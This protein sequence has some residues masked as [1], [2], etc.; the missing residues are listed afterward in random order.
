MT[1]W[2][3]FVAGI[4]GSLHCVGMCGGFACGLGPARGGPLATLARHLAYGAGRLCSYAFLGALAG[5]AGMLLMAHAGDGARMVMMQRGFAVVSGLLML[6]I[7]LRLAGLGGARGDA[8]AGTGMPWLVRSLRTLLRAPGPA[9]PLAFG[10]L[11]GLL[12]CPL[13]YAF[14]AQA[15]ASGNAPNGLAVMIAFGLGTFPAMLLMGGIG[16]WWRARGTPT[17][18]V[19]ATFLPEPAGRLDWRVHGIRA[20]GGF[21]VLLGL[22]TVARGVVP[23]SAH[24]GGHLHY[25][26]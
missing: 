16:L 6:W 25:L 18:Q 17:Q 15:A 8:L 5:H 4:A 21:I 2:L 23:L 22:I 1:H 24:L 19:H 26:H 10:V 11:N 7:G 9:A 20:A 13:V 3:I 12:P 14:V